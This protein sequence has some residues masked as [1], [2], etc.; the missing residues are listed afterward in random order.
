MFFGQRNTLGSTIEPSEMSFNVM[1]EVDSTTVTGSAVTSIS[2]SGLDLDTDGTYFIVINPLK[3]GSGA[4]SGISMYCNADT[5]ATNYHNQRITA[6]NTTL[7][8]NRYNDANMC[9]FMDNECTTITVF[10]NKLSGQE[11]MANSFSPIE[12]NE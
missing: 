7:G 1:Q 6:A 5:T 12:E 4:W 10:L 3:T 9:N 11:P 2:F 8:G